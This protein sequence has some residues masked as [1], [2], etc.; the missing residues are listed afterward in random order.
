M[1]KLSQIWPVGEPFICFCRTCP[2]NIFETRLSGITRCSG[3][4][5]VHCAPALELVISP[6]RWFLWLGT[7]FREHRQNVRYV[8]WY[9]SVLADRLCLWG[10]GGNRGGWTSWRTHA[11]VHR[12][13]NLHH[14]HTCFRNLEFMP[15]LCFQS[16]RVG[17]FLHS[18]IPYSRALLSPWERWLTTSA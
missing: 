13:V 11:H 6:K 17:F 9:W 14:T 2:T 16:L 8:Y 7:G 10:D 15:Y 3:L 1:L 4:S 12:D 18:P 5:C